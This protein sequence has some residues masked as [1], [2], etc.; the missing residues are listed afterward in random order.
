MIHS[1]AITCALEE[2]LTAASVARI[3]SDAGVSPRSLFNYY[4]VKED[5]IL[6]F[7]PPRIAPAAARRFAEGSERHSLPADTVI[8]LAATLRSCNVSTVDLRKRRTLL[9]RHPELVTRILLRM[10]E[11]ERL[12]R[13]F[14]HEQTERRAADGLPFGVIS[15]LAGAVTRFSFESAGFTRFPEDAELLE[16]IP[17]FRTALRQP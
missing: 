8:L 15:G 3:A 6:G 9:E 12:V 16:A 4:P 1:A 7:V 10:T 14:L 13:D 11:A 5:A 2:G 17:L